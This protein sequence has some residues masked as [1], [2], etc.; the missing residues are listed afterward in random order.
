MKRFIFTKTIGRQLKRIKKI[1]LLVLLISP[2]FL[3]SQNS[4]RVFKDT[5]HVSELFTDEGKNMFSGNSI[6]SDKTFCNG[7][8]CIWLSVGNFD[9]LM[10]KAIF[11]G[12]LFTGIA[13][14]FENDTLVGRFTFVG[15]EMTQVFITS[16][17]G[18]HY[19]IQ[20]FK[21]MLR[22]GEDLTFWDR[23]L[24][25]KSNYKNGVI[26]GP[27]FSFRDYLDYDL[28]YIRVHGNYKTGKKDGL[29][30]YSTTEEQWESLTETKVFNNL[31]QEGEILWTERYKDGRL[32]NSTETF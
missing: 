29:W 30:V 10:Y 12:E 18:S 32:L 15:G 24:S 14:N 7:R 6:I 28:G 16:T 11:E 23:K 22:D 25:F 3:F 4:N 31:E 2:I 9:T 8:M 17:D 5:V 20:N 26:E 27:D 13:E 1:M 21:N 19:S